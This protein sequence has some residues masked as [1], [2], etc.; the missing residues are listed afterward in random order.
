VL[1]EVVGGVLLRVAA[2]LPDED[3]ALGL[4]VPQEHLQAVDEVGPVERIA[5]DAWR[6]RRRRR[7]KTMRHE[8][9]AHLNSSQLHSTHGGEESSLIDR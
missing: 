7:R 6:R 4:G 9:E 2:D 1:L 8:R 3:D 5:P